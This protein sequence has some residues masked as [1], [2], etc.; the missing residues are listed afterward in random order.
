MSKAK[1]ARICDDDRLT[2]ENLTPEQEV[3]DSTYLKVLHM[4]KM[5][6]MC[7]FRIF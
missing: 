1:S 5:F 7:P 3:T 2:Q 6:D 4:P